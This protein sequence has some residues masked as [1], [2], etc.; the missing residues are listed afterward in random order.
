[1]M[2]LYKLEKLVH[3]PKINQNERNPKDNASP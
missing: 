2:L 1:M 3:E